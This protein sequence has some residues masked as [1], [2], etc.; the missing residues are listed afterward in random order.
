MQPLYM[1]WLRGDMEYKANLMKQ[2]ATLANKHP[3]VSGRPDARSTTSTATRTGPGHDIYYKGSL[4][5]H[6]LAHLIGD[7]PFFDV[8]APGRVWHA[9]IRARATSS[10]CTRTRRISSPR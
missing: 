3:I 8:D 7:E 2:R 9:P 5:L 1:Q 6:T 4:V 10:R